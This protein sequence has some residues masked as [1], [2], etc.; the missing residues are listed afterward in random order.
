MEKEKKP[1]VVFGEY[2]RSSRL[3]LLISQVQLAKILERTQSWLSRIESGERRLPVGMM[4]RVAT[5]LAIP[6]D[7][8]LKKAA[9]SGYNSRTMKSL[10][11]N[12][13]ILNPMEQLVQALEPL[14]PAQRRRVLVTAI[15]IAKMALEGKPETSS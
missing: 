1:F 5:A 15:R 7:D 4:P 13:D 2:I 10:S 14:K 12:K 11:E 3:E 6:L 8:F 9:E